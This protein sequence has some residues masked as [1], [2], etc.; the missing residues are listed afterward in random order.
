L[1][2]SVI[3]PVGKKDASWKELLPDL[4]LL[5]AEDEVIFVA[6]G[7]QGQ[8]I[9]VKGPKV[10][11]VGS[12][13]GRAKQL[14]AGARAAKHEALWFLHC[15]SRFTLEAVDGLRCS[16]QHR[17]DALHF[18]DLKFLRDGPALMRI[19]ELGVW[20]RSRILRLPFGDQGFC[21]SRDAFNRLGGFEEGAPYGED[22]LL[23]WK[24][25]QEG[26]EVRPVGGVL[27]TSARKYRKGWA[28]TTGKHLE[29]TL[30]QAIP[31]LR[32]LLEKRR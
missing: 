15:D 5:S 31:E 22:H 27:S 32:R 14:N 26:V 25:H 2:L 23:V 28:R 1:R 9:A 21:L 7:L 19:T 12:E 10:L 29:L 18:F 6:T 3:I 8:K 13:E 20:I 24:A 4:E 11:V 16:V 17:P 30:R